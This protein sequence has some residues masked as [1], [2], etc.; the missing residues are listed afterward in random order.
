MKKIAWFIPRVTKGSGGHRTIIQHINLLIDNGYQCDI[1]V[2]NDVSYTASQISKQINEYY[3]PCTAKVYKGWDTNKKYDIVFATSW[4]S[5]YYANKVNAKDKFYFV[6]DFEPWFFSMGDNH[7]FAENTYRMNFKAITIGKWLSHKLNSEYNMSSQYFSFC[8]DL[9]TYKNLDSKKENAICII[10]QPNKPRRCVNLLI[11]TIKIINKMN[12]DIKIYLYGSEKQDIKGIKVKHLGI[13]SP[14]ELNDLYNRCKLGVSMSSSN[15]SRIP[16]EMMAS[17]LP[18][19]ELY[20]ENN[21]YDMPEDAVLLSESTPEN[22][23][24]NIIELY[25]NAKLRKQMSEKASEYMKDY[26]LGTDYIEFM[27]AFN[28]LLEGKNTIKRIK[29]SYTKPIEVNEKELKKI[30]NHSDHNIDF[31]L[32]DNL[33]QSLEEENTKLREE[34]VNN[35]NEMN[36]FLNSKR[37]KLINKVMAPLDIIERKIKR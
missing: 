11:S 21:L 31:S 16:F 29:K 36:E 30:M 13:L 35:L 6:Q 32:T 24:L 2:K 1:Y 20:R 27:D 15:P 17:G 8:A 10:F 14:K 33:I 3:M 19:V 12:P 5:A 34:L 18:V 28:N 25:K 37:W 22:L 4:D 9:E 23:A 7:L 26:P